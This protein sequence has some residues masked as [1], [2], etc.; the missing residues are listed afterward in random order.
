MGFSLTRK[1][2]WT[3]VTHIADAVLDSV[4][5]TYKKQGEEQIAQLS[6]ENTLEYRIIPSII[7]FFKIFQ[8]P[9][10]FIPTLYY[11]FRNIQNSISKFWQYL[12]KN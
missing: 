8:L 7:N 10:N 12:Y 1:L 5:V 11:Q 9:S 3:T 6:I 4:L 2:P